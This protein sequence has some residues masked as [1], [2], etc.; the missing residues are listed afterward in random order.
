VSA[1]WAEAGDSPTMRRTV[2]GQASPTAVR[3]TGRA[4]AAS[5][6]GRLLLRMPPELHAEL[7]RAAEQSGTSL[8]SY[9][10]L[11]LAAT[12]GT[13]PGKPQPADTQRERKLLFAVL[14]ANAVAVGLAAVVAAAIALAVVLD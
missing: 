1:G 3:E 5:P 10:T 9:I 4:R 8:N 7:T 12:V 6:S 2:S 14:V 13:E 11:A